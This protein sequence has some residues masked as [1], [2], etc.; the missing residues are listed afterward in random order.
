[1]YA[2]RETK[3]L[4]MI[5]VRVEALRDRGVAAWSG[6]RSIRL[7]TFTRGRS[8]YP[9]AVQVSR[10]G[11]V[12]GWYYDEKTTSDADIVVFGLNPIAELEP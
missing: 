9:S 8:G 11:K 10:E 2:N 5:G 7:A 1:L 3:E 6:Q 12:V 4:R